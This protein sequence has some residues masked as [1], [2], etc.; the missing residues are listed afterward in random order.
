MACSFSSSKFA[1]RAPEGKV[2]LRAFVGGTHS[3]FDLPGDA[4]I[5]KVGEELDGFLGI[6]GKPEAAVLQR[7]PKAMAQGAVPLLTALSAMM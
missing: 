1:G 2:L 7:W 4:L 5:Q 6:H 3:D